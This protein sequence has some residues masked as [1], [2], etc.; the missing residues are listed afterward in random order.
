MQVI[1][2][3]PGPA[4]SELCLGRT[5]RRQSNVARVTMMK[6][7]SMQKGDEGSVRGFAFLENRPQVNQSED[8][9]H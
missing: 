6:L 3:H 4:I 9:E 8:A 1:D 7:V 5:K 2:P